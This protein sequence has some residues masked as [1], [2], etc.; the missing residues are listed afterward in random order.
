VRSA[1]RFGILGPLEVLGAS[2]PV[3]VRAG[4][5]RVVMATLLLQSNRFVSADDLIDRLWGDSP[6][7]TARATVHQ[8]VMRLR[9]TLGELD[10][11]HTMPGGYLIDVAPGSLDVERFRELID[12]SRE[13]AVAE[14]AAAES[15]ALQEALSLWRGSPLVDV[16]SPSLQRDEA[17]RLIEQR[18]QV[19]ERRLDVELVLGRH[20]EI[21]AELRTLTSEHPLRERFWHQLMT[22][23]Y[24]CGRQ[25][26][27]LEA[28]LAVRRVLG[29][30]LGVVP[31]RE[32][33]E[34]HEAILS[35]RA[36][37]VTASDVARDAVP[38]TAILV[39]EFDRVPRQ[40]P[41]DIAAFVG[42]DEEL[43][44]LYG[45]LDRAGGTLRRPVI[46]AV[47]GP[48][49]IGKSALAIRAAHTV[50]DRYPGGQL[51][52]DLQGASPGLEPL[53]QVE[54]LGRFIRAS[55]APAADLP[56]GEAELAAKYRTQLAGR[57][58]LIVLDNAVAAAQVTAL[59]PASP[60]CAVIVTSRRLL[61]TV[62]AVHIGVGQLRAA[63]S[64]ELLARLAGPDRA[65]A[66]PVA[67]AEVAA[68]CGHN[69]LALRIVASR[70]A[71]RP[72]LSFTTLARRLGDRRLQELE[73][74]DLSLRSCFDISYAELLAGGAGRSSGA[75]SNVIGGAVA[76]RAFRLLGLLRAPDVTAPLVA[77]LLDSSIP[78][79]EAAVDR[80]IDLRLVEVAGVPGRYR[81]HDLLRLYA[82]ELAHHNDPPQARDAALRRVLVTLHSPP[83]LLS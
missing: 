39:P 15:S 66:E 32:L 28:Y 52:A 64:V 68:C 54:V 81:M 35:G 11:V 63:E 5:H 36:D 77:A 2:G 47:H 62:P 69:P 75:A 45:A 43:T 25:A 12:R 13:L 73:V 53:S 38:G 74:D 27:A 23:L 33:R 83:C 49:G 51:Y 56:T 17:P 58:M 34:L 40:L 9:Q 31:G 24:R 19:V 76:A 61:A 72:D 60:D 16:P 7:S 79:A 14:D 82:C 80:L 44:A 4:K 67:A 8:Y 59:L 37:E 6:V 29:E 30:E 46:A 42:R 41:P 65:A 70:L 22:T 71:G 55:G 10:I 18:L 1:T 78:E 21:V 57:R 20:A 50:A 26:E 3:A 48:G